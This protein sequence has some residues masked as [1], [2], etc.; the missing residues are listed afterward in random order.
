[1]RCIMQIS[2][3]VEPFNQAVRA[4]TADKTIARILE[5]AKPEAAYFTAKDGKRGGILIIDLPSASDIPRFAEPWI[6]CTS[7][8][9]SK[10]C[11]R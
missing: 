11:P 4:G 2:L 5:D 1:M 3:P 9:P 8:P 7:T 6:S 10:S